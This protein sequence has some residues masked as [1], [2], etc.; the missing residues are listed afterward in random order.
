MTL[1]GCIV[2]LAG[3]LAVTNTYFIRRGRRSQFLYILFW[4]VLCFAAIGI[5]HWELHSALKLT[6]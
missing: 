5:Y 3:L 1:L 6:Q 2:V 4:A